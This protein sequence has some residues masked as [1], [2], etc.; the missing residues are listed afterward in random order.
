MATMQEIAKHFNV[1]IQGMTDYVKKHLQEIN[2]DG[3]HASIKAGKW[4][5]DEF[6][7]R[8]LEEMRG[9]GISGVME[10]VESQKVKDLEVMVD[11]LQTALLVAQQDTNKALKQVADAERERRLLAESA[12]A[13]KEELAVLRERTESQATRLQELEQLRKDK[14]EL[15]TAIVELVRK[16]DELERRLRPW[17]KRLFD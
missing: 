14:D 6:A 9:W 8:R 5:F 3:E 1:S 12:I 10:A 13:E 16:N 17:W 15:E 2:V 7:V 4:M 11:N